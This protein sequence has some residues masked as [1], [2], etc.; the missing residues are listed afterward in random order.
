MRSS[1]RAAG[2]IVER[3]LEMTRKAVAEGASR[4]MASW[5]GWTEQRRLKELVNLS[6]EWE[7]DFWVPRPD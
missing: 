4:L 3:Y 2:Q 5:L 6:E 7:R 1:A